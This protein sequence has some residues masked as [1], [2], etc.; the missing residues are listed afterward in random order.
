MAAEDPALAAF[1]EDDDAWEA[2]DFEALPRKLEMISDAFGPSPIGRAPSVAS[3]GIGA[4]S[5][6]G[7]SPPR[8]S[9]GSFG[10]ARP[11]GASDRVGGTRSRGASDRVSDGDAVDDEDEDWD[12]E[13]GLE[14]SAPVGQS[15]STVASGSD[16]SDEDWDAMLE[17]EAAEDNAES[18]DGMSTPKPPVTTTGSDG[19]GASSVRSRTGSANTSVA[20]S[21]EASPL[22]PRQHRVTRED[23]QESSISKS[24]QALS[25][26]RERFAGAGGA[27]GGASS[28]RGP[29]NAQGVDA[30]ACS[31]LLEFL[32]S[33]AQ[34][35]VGATL[36]ES[37]SAEGSS[38]TRIPRPTV[39]RALAMAA[40]A[41]NTIVVLPPTERLRRP[42]LL[43]NSAVHLHELAPPASATLLQQWLYA[44]RPNQ[45]V[46]AL[47]LPGEVIGTGEAEPVAVERVGRSNRRSLG[48]RGSPERRPPSNQS[49]TRM[50]A[51]SGGGR[52]SPAQAAADAVDA[53]LRRW[54]PRHVRGG[55]A[56]PPPRPQ[57]TPPP[58][59]SFYSLAASCVS[60]GESYARVTQKSLV[61]DGAARAA[62]A[63]G[64]LNVRLAPVDKPSASWAF[65]CA[66]TVQALYAFEHR[67]ESLAVAAECLATIRVAVLVAGERDSLRAES[68]H[69]DTSDE[70]P[71]SSTRRS[72]RET[73]VSTV[74]GA[75]TLTMEDHAHVF[76]TCVRILRVALKL[77]THV[78]D[79]APHAQARRAFQEAEAT[80]AFNRVGG[81]SP[82]VRASKV[83]GFS[84]A[85]LRNVARGVLQS[86]LAD[87][88][89]FCRTPLQ[90]ALL[91]SLQ[92]QG[93]AQ[94][95]IARQPL[96]AIAVARDACRVVAQVAAS[97][98]ALQAT[99]APASDGTPLLDML[100]AHKALKHRRPRRRH[101]A[102][103]PGSLSVTTGASI[104][105]DSFEE[106]VPVEDSEPR[107]ASTEGSKTI[108]GALEV[109]QLSLLSTVQSALA[110][111]LPV[112]LFAVGASSFPEH[113]ELEWASDDDS[114]DSEEPS[115]GVS[116]EGEESASGSSR[117][118]EPR[119][120][121]PAKRRTRTS[122]QW[123]VVDVDDGPLNIGVVTAVVGRSA[124]AR[125]SLLQHPL[126]MLSESATPLR[127]ADEGSSARSA[128]A[129]RAAASGPDLA[130]AII[131][132]LSH[133][134]QRMHALRQLGKIVAERFALPSAVHATEAAAAPPDRVFRGPMSRLVT[135]VRARA[136]L[137]LSQAA[138]SGSGRTKPG[139]AQS[140][141]SD[142]SSSGSSTDSGSGNSDGSPSVGLKTQPSVRSWRSRRP[143][144][145]DTTR[146]RR[147]RGRASTRRSSVDSGSRSKSKRRSSDGTRVATS[148][149]DVAEAAAYQAM[150]LL[151]R[152]NGVCDC[153]GHNTDLGER[154]VEAAAAAA[155][156]A[157]AGAVRAAAQGT[158]PTVDVG[159][160]EGSSSSGRGRRRGRSGSGAA[161]L[162]A[163]FNPPSKSD[164][165][166]RPSP[167]PRS[168]A[169][170]GTDV[171]LGPDPSLGALR[172]GFMMEHSHG[173]AT[174]SHIHTYAGPEQDRASGYSAAECSLLTSELGTTTLLH[175]GA[176]LLRHGKYRMA[177]LAEEAALRVLAARGPVHSSR[178]PP[179]FRQLAVTCAQNGDVVRSLAY[180]E[181]TLARCKLRGQLNE[182]IYIVDVLSNM[183][184]EHG[185]FRAARRV[186]A[187][188]VEYVVQLARQRAS[189]A[190]EAPSLRDA[191][192]R[193]QTQRLRLQYARVCIASGQPAEAAAVL[194]AVIREAGTDRRDRVHAMM[195]VGITRR[196]HALHA[197]LALAEV[198]LDRRDLRRCARVL[199]MLETSAEAQATPSVARLAK[200]RAA[201]KGMLDSGARP[202]SYA[203]R[204]SRP[205]S[206]S[207]VYEPAVQLLRA[208]SLHASGEYAAAL[209]ALAPLI[210]RAEAGDVMP[211]MAQSTQMMAAQAVSP[212]FPSGA[213]G[214]TSTVERR[215]R[216]SL[217]H[218]S[219]AASLSGRAE[220]LDETDGG[221]TQSMSLALGQHYYLRGK[222]LHDAARRPGS[223][224]FPVTIPAASRRSALPGSA[225]QQRTDELFHCAADLLL[226]A[227]QSFRRAYECFFG[228]GDDHRIAQAASQIAE[229]YIDSL[230]VPVALL[231]VPIEDALALR[232]LPPRPAAAKD[233]AEDED[234][235][236][237]NSY[238]MVT[239]DFSVAPFGFRI[240][241]LS[242][243]KR[244][245]DDARGGV[246]AVVLHVDPGSRASHGGRVRVGDILV[247]VDGHGTRG[248]EFD[249]VVETLRVAAADASPT[250]VKRIALRRPVPKMP[251]DEEETKVQELSLDDAEAA[252]SLALE[253]NVRTS[254]PLHLLRA[255]LSVAE[256]HYL[257]GTNDAALAHWLE[258][259]DL[260]VLLFVDGVS[261][262]VARLASPAVLRRLENIVMRLV[263]LLF[264]FDQVMVNTNLL[265]LDV[266]LILQVEASRARGRPRL[267]LNRTGHRA[268]SPSSDAG[269]EEAAM[270]SGGSDDGESDD[271]H[272]S[273]GDPDREVLAGLHSTDARLLSATVGSEG[274]AGAGPVRDT[275]QAG[276]R[277]HDGV[278]EPL[279][280][281]PDSM[282]PELGTGNSTGRFSVSSWRDSGHM[283]RN[284]RSSS[285]VTTAGRIGRAILGAVNAT[286][287]AVASDVGASIGPTHGASLPGGRHHRRLEDVFG[288]SALLAS[289][290]NSGSVSGKS[291]GSGGAGAARGSRR[292][293]DPPPRALSAHR[294]STAARVGDGRP[295]SGTAGS[296]GSGGLLRPPASLATVSHRRGTNFAFAMHIAAG[297]DSDTADSERHAA[298]NSDAV[299]VERLWG[300]VYLMARQSRRYA[301]GVISSRQLRLINRKALS[302]MCTIMTAM[303]AQSGQPTLGEFTYE[304]LTQFAE[305]PWRS[306]AMSLDRAPS[307]T[308]VGESA[309][310]VAPQ[311]APGVGSV[312]AMG[313]FS[314]APAGSALTGRAPSPVPS[315][316][317]SVL[318]GSAGGDGTSV[319]SGSSS[320]PP[321]REV[322]SE[323]A[324][325]NTAGSQTMLSQRLSRS[326]YVLHLGDVLVYYAPRTGN[327]SVHNL[328][329]AWRVGGETSKTRDD[330]V[331]EEA[332]GDTV[333]LAQATA[334]ANAVAAALKQLVLGLTC[335]RGDGSRLPPGEGV[336][337]DSSLKWLR[338]DVLGVPTALVRNLLV[339]TI[340]EATA[341]ASQGAST[342][343]APS[344]F[345]RLKR[346]LGGGDSRG[347]HLEAPDLVNYARSAPL[348]LMCSHGLQA[349]P[350]EELLTPAVAG[351]ASVV[352]SLCQL[353]TVSTVRQNAVDAQ[354]GAALNPVSPAAA[355]GISEAEV[356]GA[357]AKVAG[358]SSQQRPSGVAAPM[359]SADPVTLC[360]L[361][362]S[363]HVG[364]VHALAR[365]ER[366]EATRKRWSLARLAGSVAGE[367]PT[368]LM[369]Q[370]QLRSDETVEQDKFDEGGAGEPAPPHLSSVPRWTHSWH[371]PLHNP[372][373]SAKKSVSSLASKYPAIRFFECSS[374]RIMPSRVL[375]MLDG[376]SSDL[377]SSLVLLACYGDLAEMGETMLSVLAYRPDCT[378]L[379]VSEQHMKVAGRALCAASR[380]GARAPVDSPLRSPFTLINAVVVHLRRHDGASVAMFNAPSR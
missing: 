173:P 63:V 288:G 255:Y 246:G 297:L 321:P 84:D 189:S 67:I 339:V 347:S 276:V 233:G 374:L 225:R 177:V 375:S 261:V 328:S 10:S 287:G 284:V 113:D 208:K 117:D 218:G 18:H 72:R 126:C 70:D 229:V 37:G 38:A 327:K 270:L 196:S 249:A 62:A 132:G 144:T 131:G 115:G 4:G 154:S 179:L 210:A 76:E 342:R 241:P 341:T 345:Q 43:G 97:S 271:D 74:S 227:I 291:T 100:R 237:A 174:L 369:S 21:G 275:A 294:M 224:A 352:R 148:D 150:L 17:R 251:D 8:V 278:L 245:S 380:V 235:S 153:C 363:R 222:I 308:A 316:G 244:D 231:G 31:S 357:E 15:M 203:V 230:F 123:P 192:L 107:L 358:G 295:P 256:V 23:S 204:P 281:F 309:D 247:S 353:S 215:R 85:V 190:S 145:A 26:L 51:D 29:R 170:A 243:P 213:D 263:R 112:S 217:A 33:E 120:P 175:F 66:E 40:A 137:A 136:L 90:Q 182:V 185:Q 315:E 95:R 354:R 360:V 205:R 340:A 125:S 163:T 356:S 348:V 228:F 56:S 324:G 45:D 277:A 105:E 370:G 268:R 290:P 311:A 122:S 164:S 337:S 272:E 365:V 25:G 329:S 364:D 83:D 351:L 257:R 183:R 77:A 331:A 7:A 300:L 99:D 39:S 78:P 41:R 286:Q 68:S 362:F 239:V 180:Y 366:S 350:W 108:G 197:L 195:Q 371:P 139:H 248:V 188:A 106:L 6:E 250:S 24:E 146:G 73:I 220:R 238:V 82:A 81:L 254:S 35:T 323:S 169:G 114:D 274:G 160:T 236:Q 333:P 226:A 156:A 367:L 296:G 379:F 232:H 376:V 104:L 138:F 344:V 267:S 258:A 12:A 28:G 5:V 310:V 47:H 20:G 89:A 79:A 161:A 234:G 211:D 280:I 186:V 9:S 75:D 142:S 269:A 92:I 172:A 98:A 151:H 198:Y 88:F 314:W 147:V 55:A 49:A 101:K 292:T 283:F 152:T 181:R 221:R 343:R 118:T 319:G 157:T 58:R 110:R 325:S 320:V 80:E 119:R 121:R 260:F 94:L 140:S 44:I 54:P 359:P 212:R 373:A 102:R 155:A 264:C 355:S 171:L 184:L 312:A 242:P 149:A 372:L 330:G 346:T 57:F 168:V 240:G 91:V 262:P 194:H 96:T 214:S 178:V 201:V 303:R 11:R 141:S 116:G 53:S 193:V 266:L 158:G 289:N 306:H 159:A 207:V 199:R 252:A 30:A 305:A 134:R 318:E 361:A 302:A 273:G 127:A 299:A 130:D 307:G 162:L 377:N 279:F 32:E 93:R 64:E 50:V 46:D 133:R 22:S 71:A 176:V 103:A 135:W 349:V 335:T 3:G 124:R 16:D 48:R 202:L 167:S 1:V 60:P 326:L 59:E 265:L 317:T 216:E 61:G 322:R 282:L 166:A 42:R 301:D 19:A 219:G 209:R 336:L 65:V 128:A 304:R 129:S 332:K 334:S 223:I 206:P 27:G 111:Q 13:F 69:A 200:G 253:I 52:P 87:L 259:R 191:A 338:D 298:G 86:G 143:T 313:A 109:L 187:E 378:V 368:H 285:N 14:S 165:P 36:D 293:L 34:M 2:E